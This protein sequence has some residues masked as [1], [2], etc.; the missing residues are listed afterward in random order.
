MPTKD[1]QVI[2]ATTCWHTQC[3]HRPGN[4]PKIPLSNNRHMP[5]LEDLWFLFLKPFHKVVANANG[6]YLEYDTKGDQKY[7]PKGIIQMH[8]KGGHPQLGP[9]DGAAP[10]YS[11]EGVSLATGLSWKTTMEHVILWPNKKQNLN[12]WKS[13]RKVRIRLNFRLFIS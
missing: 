9:S 13:L 10:Y 6:T 2:P 1:I 3:W 7:N 11:G 4:F 12:K 8:L 5:I